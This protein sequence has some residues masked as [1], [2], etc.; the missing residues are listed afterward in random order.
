MV[1]NMKAN[2]NRTLKMGLELNRGPTV[3]CSKAFIGKARSTVKANTYG[4]TSRN[5]METGRTTTFMALVYTSGLMAESSKAIG[6]TTICTV[7]EFIHGKMEESTKESTF[8]IRSMAMVFT[9][10]LTVE[11][12][13]EN[14]K[15]VNSMVKVNTCSQIRTKEKAFG[16]MVTE[17]SGLPRKSNIN[18]HQVMTNIIDD[19]FLFI[20]MNR[21]IFKYFIKFRYI[22]FIELF[23]TMNLYH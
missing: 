8:K 10:G 16:R 12:T 13:M 15:T 18:K 9:D 4:V 23:I 1:P 17:A 20:S 14:G 5:T 11:N 21:L 19:T 3:Q 6:K 22:T 7:K 2:G